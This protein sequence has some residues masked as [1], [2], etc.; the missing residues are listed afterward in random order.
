MRRTAGPAEGKAGI[1]LARGQDA[2]AAVARE[3][4]RMSADGWPRDRYDGPGGGLSSA[5]GGGLDPYNGGGADRYNGGGLDRYNGGGLD[6]FNGG[7]LDRYNGGGLDAYN[8]G[9]L[10]RYNGGGLDPYGGGLS[11][12][13]GGGLWTGPCSRPYRSRTP[14]MHVWIPLLREHGHPDVADILAKAHEL[15]L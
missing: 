6:A 9:G 5:A 1:G 2:N 8:G 3:K 4:C 11:A 10:D 7:G 12:G 14:P 13:P 15:D